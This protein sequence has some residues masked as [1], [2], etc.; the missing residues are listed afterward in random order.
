MRAVVTGAGGFIGSHL[1][2]RL[3]AD[4]V[5]VAVVLRPTSDRTRISDLIPSIHVIRGDLRAVELLEPAMSRFAPDAVF[6]TAWTG[7]TG[8]ERNDPRQIEENV[9]P[10]V[11]LARAASR[12]GAKVFVGLGSQAEYG[13][14]NRRTDE[15]TPTRPTT[16]YGA[17]KLA[18]GILAERV[19]AEG[20]IRFAWL[21]VFSTFG[22]MDHPDWLLP[23][24]IRTLASGQR[25][26]LTA[27][28]QRWDFLYVADAVD[29]LVRVAA[30]PDANGT[31]NLGSGV[32]RPLRAVVE[33]VRDLIDPA[34]PLGFGELPYRADQI[35]HL[36][37]DITRLTAAAGWSPATPFDQ[38]LAR[39][40][41]Y[42]RG[43]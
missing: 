23:Y 11:D 24:L 13:P 12:V 39:T 43:H 20:G 41:D 19:C 17:A 21:R 29:A 40:V 10:T 18:S 25:P 9:L 16:L 36:E 32:A 30:A 7:V 5:S 4:G 22:P 38:A 15:E 33:Q 3:V 27:G 1:T 42:F 26:A 2:R 35:M 34:R 28:E 14:V 8:K 37:A 31:F 6:H